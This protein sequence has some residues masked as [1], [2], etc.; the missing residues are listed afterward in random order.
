MILS[1]ITD[2]VAL[3]GEAERAGIDRIVIDLEREGKAER[4]AGRSLFQ[5]THELDAVPRVKAA[6]RRADLLVR[7]NPLSA[8]TPAEID[9]VLAGGADVVMLPYFFTPADVR[10]F[11]GIVDGRCRVSLLV[12]TKS[13]AAQLA[14]CLD[15]G[16]VD[17]V[18]IGL[19]DLSIELGYDVILEP[20]CTGVIDGLAAMLR[21]ARIPFGLGGLGRLSS[22]M[23]P[24]GPER[25]LAEQ[26]RL[27][28]TRA[29]LGR[30]FRDGL[31][32]DRLA[33]EVGVIRE[34][35]ERWHAAPEAERRENRRLL[36]DEI[37][38]WKAAHAVASVPD[39]SS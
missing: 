11:L 37:R 33:A 20:L 30:T 2:D 19:N 23:L 27:G 39:H 26:V 31:R 34:A 13:A 36:I 5:S 8:R 22:D 4:Q 6:L 32:G 16:R 25:L 9:A 12:E 28:C 24:V 17:E 7:V 21:E 18:H 29:W 14:A 10:T 38:Q 3:A 1:L 15:A 35:V